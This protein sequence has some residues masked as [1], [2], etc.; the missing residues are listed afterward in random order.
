V[1]DVI[2]SGVCGGLRV[3][4]ETVVDGAS[5]RGASAP[6][7][8]GFGWITDLAA[9]SAVR[10]PQAAAAI[11]AKL[12][13]LAEEV[14]VQYSLTAAETRAIQ[15]LVAQ[16]RAHSSQLP[17]VFSHGDAATWNAVRLADGR[18]AF[19]DW[20]AGHAEG[21]PLWDLWYFARSHVM[22]S[23]R[24]RRR[25]GFRGP[26]VL[27]ALRRDPMLS[28]AVTEY[29]SRLGIPAEVVGPLFTLCWADRALRE[30][31]RLEAGALARGHY[32]GLVR[33]LL[34]GA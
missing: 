18:V 14:A 30:V 11:E 4:A 25:L 15:A 23:S 6:I 22:S 2:F 16:V 31:T 21:V 3:L 9:N 26:D 34:A 32:I 1:P 24:V 8:R 29:T 7:A 10:G 20:E 17:T 5:L 19:L 13:A 12:A 33:S 27:E 28:A